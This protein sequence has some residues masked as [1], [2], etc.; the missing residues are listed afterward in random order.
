MLATRPC[1]APPTR[2]FAFRLLYIRYHW[3]VPACIGSTQIRNR[4]ASQHGNARLL[5]MSSFVDLCLDNYLFWYFPVSWGLY[6]LLCAQS[7]YRDEQCFSTFTAIVY[8]LEQIQERQTLSSDQAHQFKYVSVLRCWE[9]T[10]HK[11]FVL[12]TFI[13]FR[14]G[15]MLY[16]S[17][18]LIM[19]RSRVPLVL[20]FVGQTGLLLMTIMNCHLIYRLIK[21]D[22]STKRDWEHTRDISVIHSCSPSIQ[23]CWWLSVNRPETCFCPIFSDSFSSN[24][25]TSFL[26]VRS[27]LM[28]KKRGKREFTHKWLKLTFTSSSIQSEPNEEV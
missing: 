8:L 20:C 14:F 9:A 13:I 4:P 15:M 28:R 12:V 25:E 2:M 27:L 22:Y 24:K 3:Y 6:W 17:V 7:L 5:A 16:M 18:W 1:D 21:S 26:L 23:R 11:R 19:N 10:S